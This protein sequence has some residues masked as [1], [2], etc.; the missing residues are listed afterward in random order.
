MKAK[1]LAHIASLFLAVPFVC[2]C[3]STETVEPDLAAKATDEI[4]LNISSPEDAFTRADNGYKLRYIAKIFQG[5]TSAAW[6]SVIS[7]QELIDGESNNRIVFKVDPDKDYAIMVFAD[8]IP[9]DYTA[10][11]NGL[12]KDYFYNTQSSRKA[13]M[14]TTPGSDADALS[15]LFFNNPNYDA[16]YGIATFHKEEAEK[17]VDMTLKR[18]SA[19][20]IFRDNSGLSG[21]CNVTVNKIGLRKTYDFSLQSQSSTPGAS[22]ANRNLGDIAIAETATVG[23]GNSDIFYFYTLADEITSPQYVSTEFKVTK[24]GVVSDAVSVKEIPVKSNYRTIVTG[25]FLPADP[26]TPGPGE[27]E[28]TKAG[29]IILNLSTDF[30]WQQEPLSK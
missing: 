17:I 22:E 27:D 5:S 28:T 12:Y 9:A 10:D 24:E 26:S 18:A 8:Y 19:Q 15:P 14:R 21:S 1:L 3:V 16:F 13:V 30:S 20:V 23:A 4:V 29:D 11:A 25:Q 7:R 6:T 2:S